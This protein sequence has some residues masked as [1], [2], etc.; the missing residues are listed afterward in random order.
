MFNGSYVRSVLVINTLHLCTQVNIITTY[1][2]FRYDI[3]GF[4]DADSDTP[5]GS[6]NSSSSSGSSSRSLPTTISDAIAAVGS[7][8]DNFHPK[9]KKTKSILK[10]RKG[11]RRTKARIFPYLLPPGSTVP[12]FSG[13]DETMI[14]A[15]VDAGYGMYTPSRPRSYRSCRMHLI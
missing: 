5:A 4:S 6:S 13:C 9:K 8:R 11:P 2:N 7:L 12:R 3:S 10:K 14:R 1:Y 15:H